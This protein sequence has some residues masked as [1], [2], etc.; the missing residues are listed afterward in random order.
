[1]AKKK[2]SLT[3]AAKKKAKLK[4]SKIQ[5]I[6]RPR[7]RAPKNTK[8]DPVSGTY[9]PYN[10]F[11]EATLKVANERLRKLEKVS[12]LAESSEEYILMKKYAESYPKTKGIIYNQK[13]LEEGKLRFIGKR[14]YQ[15]LTPE[16]QAYFVE[17]INTFMSAASTTAKG[18]HAAH[19]KSYYE[20]MTR[21][22]KNYPG[23]TQK[24]YEDFF[25]K[26][27]R[28][29]KV[30]NEFYEYSDITQALK[31][32]RLDQAMKDHQIDKVMELIRKNKWSSIDSRYL[33]RN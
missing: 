18:I 32:I 10:P 2:K 28:Y 7:G 4:Q 25:V 6:K 22:G 8:W 14:E 20:F 27:N 29:V 5:L 13:L 1:M 16:Q 17:R 26:Y 3:G 23:L 30:N 21:Y 19:K 11:P 15:K 31:F 9:E 24:M 33:L 12:K